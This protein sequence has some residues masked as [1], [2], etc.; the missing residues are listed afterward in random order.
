MI[1]APSLSPWLLYHS[2]LATDWSHRKTSLDTAGRQ[3]FHLLQYHWELLV[4]GH[5]LTFEFVGKCL[6]LQEMGLD[7]RCLDLHAQKL[8]K[9]IY[10]GLEMLE[11]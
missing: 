9:V 5:F 2:H 3:V 8:E 6:T 4:D 1:P 7:V 10:K 11:K